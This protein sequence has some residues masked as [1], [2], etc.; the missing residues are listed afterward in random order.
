MDEMIA[1]ILEIERQCSA[2]VERAELECGRKIETHKRLLEEKK[3]KERTR[4]L[5][6]EK[7]RLTQAVEEAKRQTEA[8]SAAFR[9]ESESLFHDSA[10]NGAIEKEILSILLV[11]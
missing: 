2:D 7:D 10:S 11:G 4:I 1:G 8:A 6:A 5:A 3:T 9:R